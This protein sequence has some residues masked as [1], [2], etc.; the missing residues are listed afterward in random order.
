MQINKLKLF[1]K[2]ALKSIRRNVTIS[3]ASISTLF[4]TL[5]ILE[6][7]FLLLLNIK[8][9]VAG[10]DPKLQIHV[11]LKSNIKITEQQKVYNTIKSI[12]GVTNITFRSKKQALT[13]LNKQLGDKAKDALNNSQ[14]NNSLLESY[15][16]VKVNKSEDI[17]II[18]AQING[19]KGIDEIDKNEELAKE[20]SSIIKVIKWI[21][22]PLFVIFAVVSLF[23]IS[24]TI[25]LA[26]YSRREEISV[27]NCLGATDW[28]IRWP[29]IFQGMIIGFL[30]SAASVI[31]IFFL[32][33]FLYRKVAFYSVEIFMNLV[34]PYFVLMNM[35]W[36][37]ML[38]GTIIGALISSLVT[39]KFLNV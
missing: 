38:I 2:D 26:I 8:M 11:F 27:M 3:I 22:I 19:L 7:F 33:S 15:Y 12:K 18:S 14:N 32:Y 39:R 34:K 21:G 31:A 20:I 36:G 16:I 13:Y 29:F 10:V 35:S 5:L 9:E 4:V 37:I 28:F 30:G 1:F 24:N 6:L 17:P 23:F 25:T